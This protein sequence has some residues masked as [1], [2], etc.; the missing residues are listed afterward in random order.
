VVAAEPVGRNSLALGLKEKDFA[1]GFRLLLV[2]GRGGC[3]LPAALAVSGRPA[4]EGEGTLGRCTYMHM[5]VITK[6]QISSACW[7]N[8]DRH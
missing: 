1:L 2:F 5:Q 3:P 8:A 7:H 6:M 4:A